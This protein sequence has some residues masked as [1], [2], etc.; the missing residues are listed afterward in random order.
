MRPLSLFL[1]G[2][3]FFSISATPVKAGAV[4]SC[5]SSPGALWNGAKDV[6]FPYATWTAAGFT[7]G[8]GNQVYSNFNPG[9][10]PTST[11]LRLIFQ[12]TA[13]G[14]EVNS[15]LFGG[16]FTSNFKITYS[17]AV[18]A[19]ISNGAIYRVTGD[20]ENP[21]EIGTPN[22]LKTVVGS[23]FFG[24][25]TS[26]MGA[27]GNP[28]A[29]PMITSLNV[30]ETYT[31]NGGAVTGIGTTLFQTGSL[32]RETPPGILVGS[33]G[34]RSRAGEDPEECIDSPDERGQ[35]LYR[36]ASADPQCSQ[37][38]HERVQLASGG[39]SIS[40]IQRLLRCAQFRG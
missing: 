13:G 23:K 32:V 36:Q 5:A 22:N 14:V 39:V 20:I 17:V 2:L 26:T 29:V 38:V 28:I 33:A 15:V 31:A 12:T 27:P 9:A 21:S 16:S 8:Q 11:T 6:I 19:S 7:C 30:T 24:S 10:A 34:G 3:V 25:L 1:L 35:R 4:I 40:V 18:D 37:F